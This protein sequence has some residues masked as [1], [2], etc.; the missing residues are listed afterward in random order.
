MFGHPPPDRLMRP[1]AS[2]SQP[3]VNIESPVHLL[4]HRVLLFSEKLSSAMEERAA[5]IK[6]SH[7]LYLMGSF[8]DGT[9]QQALSEIGKRALIE[10]AY[11]WHIRLRVQIGKAARAILGTL[12]YQNSGRVA[13]TQSLSRCF[14]DHWRALLQNSEQKAYAS[15][16]YYY[17]GSLE[18]SALGI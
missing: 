11:S 7:R 13:V 2:S 17:G 14:A 6:G 16:D 10:T 8:R 5:L 3:K 18:I 4:P 15:C 1:A 12:A 9:G